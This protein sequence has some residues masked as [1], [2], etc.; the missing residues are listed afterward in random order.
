MPSILLEKPPADKQLDEARENLLKG[1][2]KVEPG[3]QDKGQFVTCTEEVSPSLFLIWSWP[4]LLHGCSKAG[5]M[6]TGYQSEIA[7][8]L[9][10]E[11]WGEETSRLMNKGKWLWS[12]LWRSQHLPLTCDGCCWRAVGVSGKMQS[13][14]FVSSPDAQYSCPPPLCLPGVLRALLR[15]ALI[16]ALW[17]PWDGLRGT[18][19]CQG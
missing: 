2:D 14:S 1:G 3:P 8:L 5:G 19:L 16:W 9:F 6:Q 17:N 11:R 7:A 18:I 13:S 4:V 15:H 10:P 12:Q